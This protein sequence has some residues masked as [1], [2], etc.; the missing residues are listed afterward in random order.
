MDGVLH[1]INTSPVFSGCV[2]LIMNIGGKYVSMDVPVGMHSFFSHCWVRKIT[3][4][5]ISFV[6]TRDVKTA[7][8]VTLLFIL[9][10]RFLMNEKSN[11]CLHK[12]KDMSAS[13]SK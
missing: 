13:L 2:M 6:A 10:S 12:I 5:C 11:C 7:L 9:F 1:F 3:V 8:L 4:F